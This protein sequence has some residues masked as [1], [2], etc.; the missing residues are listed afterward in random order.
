MA[1]LPIPV[2]TFLLNEKRAALATIEARHGI[3]VVIIPNPHIDTPRYEVTRIRQDE[4]RNNGEA[5]A[6]YKLISEAPAVH[7]EPKAAATT[8]NPIQTPAV[9]L[10]PPPPAPVPAP[11]AAKAKPA[12]VPTERPRAPSGGLLKKLWDRLFGESKAPAAPA[13]PTQSVPSV[14]AAA[15]EEEQATTSTPPPRRNRPSANRRGRSK[16]PADDGTPAPRGRAAPRARS[17]AQPAKAQPADASV[18]NEAPEEADLE[19]SPEATPEVT[20]EGGE[21]R[22][23]RGRRGG[24]RRRRAPAADGTGIPATA[25]EGNEGVADAAAPESAPVHQEA[26]STSDQPEDNFRRIAEGE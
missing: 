26:P 1:Q 15:E 6:T 13:E 25:D 4:S 2:A 9:K 10:A 12:P 23:R 20:A 11:V 16:P 17:D 24:R 7:Y 14:T 3:A 8:R 21:T 22:S 19:A 5:D 18:I